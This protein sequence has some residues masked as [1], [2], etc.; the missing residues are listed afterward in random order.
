MGVFVYPRERVQSRVIGVD[1]SQMHERGWRIKTEGRA[2]RHLMN[3]A[4]FFERRE[5]RA[6]D[7]IAP[8]L[9]GAFRIAPRVPALKSGRLLPSGLRRGSECQFWVHSD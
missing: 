5:Y 2:P 4:A 8:P 9:C 7:I 6:E 3:E 1:L